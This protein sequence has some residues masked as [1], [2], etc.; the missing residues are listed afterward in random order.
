MRKELW[1]LF[2]KP[3]CVLQGRREPDK[4]NKKPQGSKRFY[5]LKIILPHD[6]V[7]RGQSR[8]LRGTRTALHDFELFPTFSV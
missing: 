3:V 4:V 1:Y 6:Y 2:I 7:Y 8:W 5:L